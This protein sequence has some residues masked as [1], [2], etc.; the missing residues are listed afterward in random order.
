MSET[1][2]GAVSCVLR[3][4]TGS[5][6]FYLLSSIQHYEPNTYLW[7]WALRRGRGE[8]GKGQKTN[9]PDRSQERQRKEPTL[10]TGFVRVQE[11]VTRQHWRRWPFQLHPSL[12][13]EGIPWETCSLNTD[14]RSALCSPSHTHLE[15]SDPKWALNAQMWKWTSWKLN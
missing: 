9:R 4:S 6:C 12:E 7:D 8:K 14:K 2:H 13:E 3:A 15:S 5:V 10:T 11:P 1:A